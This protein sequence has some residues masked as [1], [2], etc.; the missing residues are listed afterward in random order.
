[1]S[2][3]DLLIISDLDLDLL[4]ISV[5]SLFIYISENSFTRVNEQ[6]AKWLHMYHCC[7]FNLTSNITQLILLIVF[8]SFVQ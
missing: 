6:L 5:I 7:N 8:H 3:L 2:R 4:I 1:M